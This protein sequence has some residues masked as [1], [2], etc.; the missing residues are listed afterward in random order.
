MRTDLISIEVLYGHLLSHELRLAQAQPKVDL[1]LAG[2]H[3]ATHNGSSSRG[4]S[5]H[6]RGGRFSSNPQ[7]GRNS[8]GQ[9]PNRGRGR[10]RGFSNGS[11]PTCQICGKIGHLALTCYQRFDNSYS[12]DSNMQALLTTP[13][14]H[15]DENW[16]ADSGA[17]HHLTADLANLK[18]RAEEYQGQEQI[19]VGNGKSIPIK[20][21]GTTQLFSPT[22]SFQLNDVLHVSQISQNLL[23]IQKFTVD[24]N[25]FIELH[26]QF[27]NVKDQVTGR[28]MLHGPSRHGLYPF[29][30]SINKHHQSNKNSP[31]AFV[32]EHVSYPQWHS[33]LGHPA[34]RTVSR[35]ISRFGLLVLPN[36]N[37]KF[38]SACLQPKS[39]Q[40]SFSPSLSQYNSPLDLIYTDVWGPSPICSQHGF[41]YYVSFLDASSRYTWLY[42]MTKKSDAFNIFLQFQKY[43]E[44]FFNT[45]IKS[46]QSDRGGEYRTISTFFKNCGIVHR[47]SCP[48]THQQQGSIERKHRHIVETGLSLL[49][50]AHMPFR[51]WDDAF[52][53]ACYPHLFFKINHLLKNYSTL[54]LII[55]FS[56]PLDVHVGLIFG[57]IILTNSNPVLF[58][59]F[60]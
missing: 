57:C 52:Q 56:K 28:T 30:F 36:S 43:V 44:R 58:N 15:T 32:G 41:K 45:Q 47:V 29:P 5:S 1:S 49:S 23:S 53:T 4:G 6:G 54:F 11:R 33:R 24:T 20:H 18:V 46:V 22:S 35:I 13:Q 40:L 14:S 9:R 55:Y 38:C 26:P 25:T 37:K 39:K 2:A 31:T 17:T 34:L 7:S 48:H 60:F 10:G 51:F 42:P 21:V 27:F 50:H 19:R 3:F 8:S 16:Y 12:S 59:V